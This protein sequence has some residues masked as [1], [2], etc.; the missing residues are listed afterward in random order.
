MSYQRTGSFIKGVYCHDSGLPLSLYTE[1][2][3]P[4]QKNWGEKL[5]RG[6]RLY[7]GF[8]ELH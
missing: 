5:R 3:L 1:A 7:T 2:P 4:S 8:K 6:E